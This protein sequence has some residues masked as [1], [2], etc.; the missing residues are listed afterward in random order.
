MKKKGTLI[1]GT[2]KIR[3][4]RYIMERISD[5]A[6]REI[7]GPRLEARCSSFIQQGRVV[8]SLFAIFWHVQI[9]LRIRAILLENVQARRNEK[10]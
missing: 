9:V 8:P 1:C 3:F 4:Q 6:D 5:N 2:E 10:L 7:F